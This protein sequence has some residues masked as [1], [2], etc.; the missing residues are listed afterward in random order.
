MD[1]HKRNSPE[2][3]QVLREGMAVAISTVILALAAWTIGQTFLSARGENV[4]A[5]NRQKDIMLY[6][7]SLFGTVT[8]YYLGRVPAEVNAR[9]AE[10]AAN[11]AQQ[12]LSVSQEKLGE[13]SAGAATAR[14]QKARASKRLSQSTTELRNV[15]EAISKLHRIPR[16]VG[17]MGIRAE[18]SASEAGGEPELRE[19]KRRIDLLLAQ[20]SDED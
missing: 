9:R 15:S 5:Y 1:D 3:L 4:E 8:G 19:A 14:E 20:L 18:D 16:N 17:G 12:Q 11:V 2:F 13:A 6:V 7:V 10:K